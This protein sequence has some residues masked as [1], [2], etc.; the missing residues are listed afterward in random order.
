[1][2]NAKEQIGA[3][4][5]AGCIVT[6]KSSAAAKM[7]GAVASQVAGSL[8]KVTAEMATERR[9]NGTSPLPAGAWN[10]GYLALTNDELVLARAKQG[11]V[12]MKCQEVLARTPRATIRTVEVGSG[13][14]TASLTITF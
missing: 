13:K 9:G 3:E 1:M 5:V 7:A 8:G 2:K 11:L 10:H 14:M 12:G 6:P 4:I